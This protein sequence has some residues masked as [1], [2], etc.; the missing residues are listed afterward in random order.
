[1][2]QPINEETYEENSWMQGA[3]IPSQYFL[4]VI[5]YLFQGVQEPANKDE[6]HPKHLRHAGDIAMTK[7]HITRATVVTYKR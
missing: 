1:M 5:N 2:R 4:D 7:I 6:V 3:E